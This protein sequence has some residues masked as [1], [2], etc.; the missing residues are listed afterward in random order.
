MP[1]NQSLSSEHPGYIVIL[2]DHSYSMADSFGGTTGVSKAQA[3]AD[4]VNRVLR[5]IG[6]SCTAGRVIKKRCD[7]S[8]LSYGKSGNIVSNA[9]A[10]NLASK[11]IVTM[12]E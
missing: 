7:I 10:G 2:I 11:P 1:Y 8:V 9:F 12:P 4:A 5:E 3:C 6:L